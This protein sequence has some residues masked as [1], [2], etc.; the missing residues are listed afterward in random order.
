MVTLTC[1]VAGS[2]TPDVVWNLNGSELSGATISDRSIRY[3]RFFFGSHNQKKYRGDFSFP[4]ITKLK[5]VQ[6]KAVM[7]HYENII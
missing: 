7:K 2:P 3:D 1:P 5:W 6:R 4:D